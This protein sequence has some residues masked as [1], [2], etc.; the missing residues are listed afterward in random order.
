MYRSDLCV[1]CMP[2]GF[3]RPVGIQMGAYSAWGAAWTEEGIQ[4]GATWYTCMYGTLLLFWS[5]IPEQIWEG[6]GLCLL[7]FMPRALWFPLGS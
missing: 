6:T 3:E 1:D 7:T 2:D 5:S 4:S